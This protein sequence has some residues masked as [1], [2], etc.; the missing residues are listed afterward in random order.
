M[1]HSEFRIGQDFY[2]AKGKRWRCTDKGSRVIV[3]IQI[4]MKGES[5]YKGPP[6]AVVEEV[7]DED[8]FG[9]C[10]LNLFDAIENSS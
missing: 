4:E 5:W 10:F 6:Y 3:A 7:F 9:G 8:D 1:L 2:T